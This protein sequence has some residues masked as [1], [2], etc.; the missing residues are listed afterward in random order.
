M[1]EHEVQVRRI[2]GRPRFLSLSTWRLGGR[3]FEVVSRRRLDTRQVVP[4][5]DAGGVRYAGLLERARASRVLRG[6]PLV[7]LEPIGIDLAGVDET[8]DLLSYGRAVFSERAR[9]E[10][11]DHAL[12]VPLPSYAR[13]VGYLTEASLPLL[14][15]IVPPGREVVD[16][17]WDGAEHRVRFAP[18]AAWWR[19]LEATG[20]P[21]SEDVALLLAALDRSAM[22]ARAPIGAG[23]PDGGRWLRRQ[24]E[25]VWTASRLAAL[26]EDGRWRGEAGAAPEGAAGAKQGERLAAP[27]GKNLS[28]LSLHEVHLGAQRWEVVQPGRGAS[29]ALLPYVVDRGEAYFLLWCEGRPSVLERLHQ[30]PL[31]DA[32]TALPFVN[33]TGCFVSEGEASRVGAGGVPSHEL[34]EALLG[35][36]LEGVAVTRVEGLGRWAEPAPAVSSELRARAVVELDAAKLGDLPP[37]AFVIPATEMARAVGDGLVRDPVVAAASA[38]LAGALGPDPFVG[39]RT[40]SVGRRRA[41]VDAMTRGSQVQA[42]LR[43][44]SSIEGEQLGAPTYARLMTYLQHE[45]GVRVAY[46]KTEADRS[47]FKAAFRVFMAADRGEDRALQGLHWSHDAFHFALGNF[48]LAPLPDLAGWYAR[49]EALPEAAEEGPEFERYASALKGAEDEATFFSFWTLFH[50]QPSLARYVPQL[51]YWRALVD[52]GIEDRARA[53]AIFDDVTIRERLP[54]EVAANAVYRERADVRGLFDYMLGF[55]PYHLK[56]ITTAFRFAARDAYRGVFA[57]YGIY[58]NE[59]HRYLSGVRSFT[60]RLEAYPPGLNPLRCAWADVRVDLTLR[61]W[62]AVKA[63]K[64]V[65]KATEGL[66]TD[67]GRERRAAFFEATGPVFERLDGLWAELWALRARIKG[68]ELV[69]RNQSLHE[70]IEDLAGD[71]EA[72][73]RDLWAMAAGTGLLGADVIASE[74]VREL[75]R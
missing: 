73:R 7:G 11:D 20:A 66:A 24:G 30:R 14:L 61:V 19:E 54:G 34:A 55:K 1:V 2:E 69:P 35:R 3:V 72:L 40:S 25:R 17:A 43:A 27:E 51:T 75:P 8:G 74:L 49:G 15:P 50:E 18:V 41:F 58:E 68:A 67:V 37:G 21:Y 57:R 38:M 16:V 70:D 71:V 65:R 12:K 39:A 48:T 9:V 59:L 62:D 36:V 47:F 60:R 44:Y 32:P 33:A 4:F 64:L 45:F 53:R 13:S 28:F 5:F 52:M 26:V 10:I 46:P 31:H 56:D 63:L 6:G 42:R 22:P 29:V 23:T